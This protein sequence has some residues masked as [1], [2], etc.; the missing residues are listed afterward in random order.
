M[1]DDERTVPKPGEADREDNELHY[2]EVDETNVSGADRSQEPH[3][4]DKSGEDDT[5]E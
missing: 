1:T 2:Y 5:D 4:N 3:A